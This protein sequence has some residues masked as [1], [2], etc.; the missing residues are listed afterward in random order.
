M[1]IRPP[2]IQTLVIHIA[3]YLVR[4]S[5]SGKLVENSTTITCLE[6]ISYQI[7]LTQCYRYASN[8]SNQA[9]SKGLDE[10]T[11]CEQ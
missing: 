8:T 6:I 3:N 2:L 5:L 7:K 11:Y 1:W 10:G 4:H 9:C